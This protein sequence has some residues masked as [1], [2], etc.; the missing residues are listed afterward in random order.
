MKDRVDKPMGQFRDEVI[1]RTIEQKKDAVLRVVSG[2]T[3]SIDKSSRT[4]R[5]VLSSETVDRYGDV[6]LANAFNNPR[7][8]K[9]YFDSN[10]VLLWAHGRDSNVG[11]MPI[12]SVKNPTFST[13][14]MNGNL[15]FEG[16]VIFADV[17]HAEPIWQ[18]Y[19]QECLK[20]F[21]VGFR[22]ITVKQPSEIIG[23]TG[24]EFQEVDLLENSAVPIPA[25]PA[26]LRKAFL[27]GTAD[28]EFIVKSF[29]PLRDHVQRHSDIFLPTDW[30][31]KDSVNELALMRDEW[32]EGRLQRAPKDTVQT[33]RES[34]KI[35]EKPEEVK[36]TENGEVLPIALATKQ[37]YQCFFCLKDSQVEF[38]K[39]T[40]SEFHGIKFYDIEC[41]HC[42]TT[43]SQCL[44]MAELLLQKS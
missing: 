38:E 8:F 20:A 5:A 28:E 34:V 41:E 6:I 32:K 24:Y 9:Q 31:Y 10:P 42:K 7:N 25:N 22:P 39:F 1:A 30:H 4:I 21:S 3:K 43:M 11:D 44:E 19:Q 35:E 13:R 15:A 17:A 14:D 40:A 18:L 27:D 2:F 26:A 36:I 12:G 16:D 33:G 37:P 29:F 23:C